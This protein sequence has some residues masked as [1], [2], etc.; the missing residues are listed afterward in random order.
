MYE[1]S[2]MTIL[3]RLN[4]KSLFTIYYYDKFET[5]KEK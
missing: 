4:M 5:Q 3:D 2:L 1:K